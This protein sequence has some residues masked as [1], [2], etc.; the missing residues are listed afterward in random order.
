MKIEQSE[1]KD[2]MAVLSITLEP[3]DY[4][5][6]V[7]KQ[8]KEVRHKAQMP[9]FRP[10]MVPAGLVK[11]MY[12][13]GILADVLNKLVGENLQKH[14]EDNKD[15][16][17]LTWPAVVLLIVTVLVGT[18]G[19]T[20][21]ATDTDSKLSK[22]T[23]GAAKA[24]TVDRSKIVASETLNIEIVKDD[25]STTKKG[26]VAGIPYD[27]LVMADVDEA[28]NVRDSA[29]EEGTQNSPCLG[30]ITHTFSFEWTYF[31]LE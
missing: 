16:K 28:V 9:G 29:S 4:Q 14:I 20:V 13:K 23:A 18:W 3:A 21:S 22:V 15:M 12:G 6:E 17:K 25:S 11:K 26:E 2:L 24:V 31:T 10:G 5:E 1:I 27:K 19:S 7:A 8:L 30:H